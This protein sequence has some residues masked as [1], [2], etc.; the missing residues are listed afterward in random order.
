MC[1]KLVLLGLKSLGETYRKVLPLRMSHLK[2]WKPAQL[3]NNIGLTLY[4][5]IT[6]KNFISNNYPSYVE[7]ETSIGF[8]KRNN[9]NILNEW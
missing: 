1:L 8:T 5:K 2:I 3:Y 6:S 9:Y 4:K 7:F